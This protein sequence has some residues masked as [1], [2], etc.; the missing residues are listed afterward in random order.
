MGM[1]IA[2]KILSLQEEAEA[3]LNCGMQKSFNTMGVES[4]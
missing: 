4:L 3:S 1:G 2:L